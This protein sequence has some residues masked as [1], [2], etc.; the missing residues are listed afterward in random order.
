MLFCN[1]IFP[2]NVR[3]PKRHHRYHGITAS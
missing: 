1:V 2:L 3:T